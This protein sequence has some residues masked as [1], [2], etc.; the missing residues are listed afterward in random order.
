MQKL[1]PWQFTTAGIVSKNHF[2]IF[3]A[4]LLGYTSDELRKKYFGYHWQHAIGANQSYY[5]RTALSGIG[6]S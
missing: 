6:K 2:C 4:Q 3:A 1:K 5:Q